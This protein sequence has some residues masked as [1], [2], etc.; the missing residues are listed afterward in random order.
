V[1]GAPS[2]PDKYVKA[3][4]YVMAVQRISSRLGGIGG[5]IQN[6]MGG[7]ASANGLIQSA[8]LGIPVIDAPCNH[9]AHPIALMGSLGLHKDANYWS[10]QA[11][12]GGNKEKGQRLELLIE[13]DIDRCS[14]IIRA[15]SIQ[16]GGRVVVARNPVRASELKERAAVGA[17][18]R[19]I[20]LG[21]HFIEACRSGSLSADIIAKHLGGEVITK[22]GVV[23]VDLD[24]EGGLDVGRVLLSD[25]YELIFWNEYIL[26]EAKQN[27]LYTFPDLIITLDAHNHLPL[28]A[29]EIKEGD[30]IFLVAAKKDQ[31]ILGAGMFDRELFARV[32]QA[33]GKP[34]ISYVFGKA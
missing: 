21:K 34:V 28:M 29:A 8:V 13:G 19:T 15:A 14:A 25:G 2:A 22:A 10:I 33:I 7:L 32:E 23:R 4:D 30:E 16:T 18:A 3:I 17:L 31:I 20:D 6:E 12:C 5:I 24:T 26:L 27:R 9:R 11:A 1:V